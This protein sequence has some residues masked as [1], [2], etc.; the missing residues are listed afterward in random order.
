MTAYCTKCRNGF[1]VTPDFIG[2]SVVCPHCGCETV[3]MSRLQADNMERSRIVGARMAEAEKTRGI[4]R[5][6]FW[7]GFLFS[8]CWST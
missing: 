8:W 6:F 3:A 1:D 2:Y 7:A 4:R 5:A